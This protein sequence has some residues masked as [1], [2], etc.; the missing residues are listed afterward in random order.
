MSGKW[1]VL[2]VDEILKKLRTDPAT[3]ISKTE[4]E[5]RLA[6]LGPNRLAEQKPPSALI[7]FLEQFKNFIVWVLMVA[8]MISGFLGEWGDAIAI[9]AIVILN[10]TLGFIQES[11]A[12]KSLAALKKL[13]APTTRVLR[14]GEYS[15]IPSEQVV[16]G[17][18][19][20]LEAGDYAPADVRLINVNRFATQ[21]ASLTGESIPV[22]KT[23]DRI[24]NHE[25]AIGDRKNMAFMGTSV[26]TGKGTAVVVETGMSTELGKI[27]GLLQ[28]SE[29]EVTPLQKRLDAFGHKLV[30]FTLAIV[31]IVFLMELWRGGEFLE[32]FLIAV[33]LAVAAIPEGLPAVVTIALALGVN[34]MVKRNALI[35]KLHSVETLGSTSVIC[36]DKTGTLTQNEMTVRKV[37]CDGIEIDVS[38]VGYAPM[39]FFSRDAESLAKVLNIGVLCNS[40][41]L[42]KK[43]D[44]WKIIGDPTEG[45]LLTLAGKASI[46]REELLKSYRLVAEIPFDTERKRMTSIYNAPEG[47]I[48]AVKGAPDVILK[49]CRW[50]LD[51]REVKLITSSVQ[52][53]ILKENE[54]LA[55]RAL[56]VLGMAYRTFPDIPQ[57]IEPE[58][59]ET[60]L[61]FAGL[62]AMID[63]PR[64]EVKLAI[65]KCRDG[66]IRTVMITGDHKNTAIAI[67]TE[68]GFFN[69]NSEA[70]TGLDLDAMSDEELKKHIKQISVYARVSAENKLR[71]VRAWKDSGAVVAMTGD[72]VNDAPAVKEADIGIAM[73]ITGTDVTKDASD[74]VITDDN[75]ASIVA[76]VE[77]GRGIYA[78]IKK[79]IYFL[80]SC[81]IGEVLTMFLASLFA[82]PVPLFP[83]QIL[84]INIVTD[85]LPALALGVDPMSSSI[86]KEPVRRRDE[87]IFNWQVIK[88]LFWQGLSIAIVTLIA[89]L[90]AM[91]IRGEDISYARTIAFNVLVYTQL[92]H[93]LD[94]RS[95]S[96]SIFKLGLFTNRFLLMAVAASITLQILLHHSDITNKIFKTQPLDTIDMVFSLGI[97]VVPMLLIEG[98]KLVK[99]KSI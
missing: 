51:R 58:Y 52:E 23:S 82:M 22:N 11:K 59:I 28:G 88:R 99:R 74:M 75:F 72:G 64:P 49:E 36:S 60:D 85:G 48:A 9:I 79:F 86:M 78:N 53:E 13:S 87:E 73:G 50:Y 67:A 41:S 27:A 20:L 26:V 38:G 43:E 61:I 97:A 90:F 70:L 94:C 18:I 19:V 10:A 56:R 71:I 45:A 63:P 34:R 14:D 6:E 84:W 42:Q 32:T 31:V 1:F 55:G 95:E 69:E 83:I 46:F 5:K 30:Y 3:G 54:L 21:E 65:E 96:E 37:Y 8:A 66:G 33:S 93:A 89:F 57:N 40:A 2:S 4:A 91:N 62:V 25:V 15:I 81:N 92:F 80:L 29:E 39:G 35:R 68:L 16:P 47:I 77:E 76:A 12:Q 44:T 7:L 98:F 17:D 24:E